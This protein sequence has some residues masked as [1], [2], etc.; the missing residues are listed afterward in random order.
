MSRSRYLVFAGLWLTAV[1]MT[2]A[3][4][5]A[6]R[7]ARTTPAAAE[8]SHTILP[9]RRLQVIR[10]LGFELQ[11]DSL[12]GWNQG[13]PDELLS[14]P[15]DLVPEERQRLYREMFKGFRYCRLAAG[16]FWRGL[17]RE[18]KHYQGR[19][20]EQMDGLREMMKESGLRGVSLEYW[21]PAPFWKANNSL[22]GADQKTNVLRCFGPEFAADPVYKGDRKRFLDDF[23]KACAKDLA[24][25]RAHDIPVSFWGLANDPKIQGGDPGFA[26]C[27]YTADQYAVVFNAV[28]PV[29]RAQD[30]RMIIIAD[31]G[32]LDYAARVCK[33]PDDRAMIGA[34][35]LHHPGSDSKVV[36]P[37]VEGIRKR[38]GNDLPVFQNEYYYLATQATPA[39]C[40]NTVQ[41][42][43]NWFQLG[44]A[45]SWFWL[46]ALKPV[47]SGGAD[48]ICLGYWRPSKDTAKPPA[49]SRF[50]DLKPGHWTWNKYNW[51]AIAGFVRHMPWDCVAVDVEEE[52][53]DEDLRILAYQRPDGKLV[54]VLSNRSF[55][56]HT[57]HINPGLSRATFKGYRYTP[58]E[59][60]PD[61]MGVDA[62]TLPGERFSPKLADMSWEF[63]V[64]Q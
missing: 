20:P 14:V 42:I 46:H 36:R 12:G 38:F 45:P 6:Q 41:H 7:P 28:A 17:D 15:H 18:G 60:G 9:G 54:V 33:N 48:G 2:S 21:S 62:G 50:A 63:W 61:F 1:P 22:R 52:K 31:S 59:A 8:S 10:G 27:S 29:L 23:A 13:M 37:T 49:T 44:G 25:L 55:A 32:R 51:H 5:P 35:T 16:V 34:L 53:P 40:L 11:C 56:P 4:Y 19:W 26:T 3:Q 57:F 58:D 30:P 43:M 47:A 39:R 64:Q 24:T